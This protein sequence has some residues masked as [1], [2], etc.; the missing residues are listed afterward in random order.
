M[1]KSINKTKFICI[2]CDYCTDNKKA[3]QLHIISTAHKNRIDNNSEPFVCD[4][5]TQ[6]DRLGLRSIKN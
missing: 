6:F 3:Y 2:V 5:G 4:C 1:K